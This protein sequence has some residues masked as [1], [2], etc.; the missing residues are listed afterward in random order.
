MVNMLEAR[1][2][3]ISNELFLEKPVYTHPP[4][5]AGILSRF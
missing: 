5:T 1:M 2:L 3:A 4:I